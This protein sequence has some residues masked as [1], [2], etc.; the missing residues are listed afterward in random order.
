M[1]RMLMMAGAFIMIAGTAI[2]MML[3]PDPAVAEA[4]ALGRV[5]QRDDAEQARL[6]E[7]AASGM[8]PLDKALAHAAALDRSIGLRLKANCQTP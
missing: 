4:A 8:T 7:V 2:Y 3:P 5:V 1:G 6:A